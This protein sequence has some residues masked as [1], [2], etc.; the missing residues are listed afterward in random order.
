MQSGE[1]FELPILSFE[2]VGKDQVSIAQETS[3]C[4]YDV[5]VYIYTPIIAHHRIK[6]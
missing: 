1:D 4:W 5:F 3:V 6:H 2:L